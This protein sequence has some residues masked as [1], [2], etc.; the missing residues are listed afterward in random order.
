MD[1][2]VVEII[3]AVVVGL[4]VSKTTIDKKFL[5]IKNELSHLRSTFDRRCDELESF[6]MRNEAN[7]LG[8]NKDKKISISIY[9]EP[10]SKSDSNPN[11]F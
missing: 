6:S 11:S 3:V 4:Y 5:E 10:Q 1:S 2:A 9:H 8:D 7:L